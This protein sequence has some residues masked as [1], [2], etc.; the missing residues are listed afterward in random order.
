MRA[1]WTGAVGFGL[2]NIPIKL[3][4]AVQD[5]SL[6]LDMLDK[7]DNANIK[8]MRVNAETGKEVPW[9]NIVRGYKLDGRYVVLGDDDFKQASPDKTKIIEINEFVQETEVNTMLYENSYYLEPTKA[10]AKPYIL[11]R[12]ALQ[13]TGKVGIG[14]FVL[15][16]KESVV[17]IKPL[18]K[19]MVLNKIRF[20]EEIRES[21][22]IEIPDTKTNANE[23]KMAIALI[24]QL[25]GEFDIS[26]Y[27]DTY[28]ERLMK[29][30]KAKAKGKKLT[31][32]AMRVVHSKTKDLM[33]Q[34][35]ASLDSAK[36]KAS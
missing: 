33:S 25:T 23:L 22:D 34:L 5:S 2:V 8:F 20:A 24:E 27:K 3:Y 4:S 6:D 26:K 29:L 12:D 35:K 13:K 14:T 16:S 15:R 11:L 28:T 21:K 18:E 10:G 36:R 1:I 7:N 19:V 31:E 17:V 30:I 9:G 32:P